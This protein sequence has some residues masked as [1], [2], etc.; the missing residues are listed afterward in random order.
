MITPFGFIQTEAAPAG[1]FIDTG[2]E[3]RLDASDTTSYPGSGTTWANVSAG[4]AGTDGNVTVTSAGT[5]AW[6]ATGY[7]TFDGSS[8]KLN[9]GS[10]AFFGSATNT[11]WT[12]E[13]YVNSDI[14]GTTNSTLQLNSTSGGSWILSKW[15]ETTAAKLYWQT[16]GTRYVEYEAGSVTSGTWYHM[17]WVYDQGANTVKAYANNTELWSVGGSSSALFTVSSAWFGAQDGST[18]FFDGKVNYIAYYKGYALT[19]DDITNNYNILSARSL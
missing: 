13:M 6:D 11:S 10:P 4:A 19:T 1:G 3:L 5:P 17:L 12:I 16:G 8:Q 15:K 14:T 2:L 9:W 18:G 7:F